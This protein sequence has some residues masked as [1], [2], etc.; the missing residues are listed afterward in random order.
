MAPHRDR[1]SSEPRGTLPRK[2]L[3]YTNRSRVVPQ[4]GC[5]GFPVTV[6]SEVEIEDFDGFSGG[7]TVEI[8]LIPVGA[9]FGAPFT[10]TTLISTG[11]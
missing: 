9:T 1:A 10:F 2:P 8:Q 3:M 7:Q 4:G 6:R 11:P 5:R